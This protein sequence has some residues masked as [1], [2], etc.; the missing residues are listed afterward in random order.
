MQ[1]M[2]PKERSEQHTNTKQALSSVMKF[3]QKILMSWIIVRISK[4]MRILV[5]Y[6]RTTM[7]VIH[8]SH[9]IQDKHAF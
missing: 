5:V 4:M 9:S 1:M 3:F 2:L 6:Q 8:G 7:F